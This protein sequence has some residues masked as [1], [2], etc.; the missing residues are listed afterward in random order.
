MVLENDRQKLAKFF[1]LM[2]KFFFLI[3][4]REVKMIFVRER[5]RRRDE[6]D[7]IE[8]MIESIIVRRSLAKMKS[9]KFTR[10]QID[11]T[12]FVS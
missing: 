10:I 4:F 12:T 2:L 5:K 7:A 9:S 6:K 11:L 8:I 1:L 3:S